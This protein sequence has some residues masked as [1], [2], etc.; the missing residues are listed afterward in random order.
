M[1]EDEE[2]REANQQGQQKQERHFDAGGNRLE[3][4]VV[5]THHDPLDGR[6]DDEQYGLVGD[7]ARHV[8]LAREFLEELIAALKLPQEFQ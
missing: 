2:R 4:T 8:V 3:N 6:E 7:P 1:L 5:T